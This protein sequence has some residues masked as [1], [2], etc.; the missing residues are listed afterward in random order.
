MFSG[1]IEATGRTL[2]CE[3]VDQSLRLKLEKPSGFNDLSTGDS[4]ACNGVCLT[5]ESQTDGDMGFTLGKETLDVTGWTAESLRNQQWNLERSLRVGDRVHGHMVSG[6]VDGL[7][8][9]AYKKMAGE[10]LLLGFAL[11]DQKSPFVWNK[12]SIALNGV[13]LTVNRFEEGLVEVCL[14]PETLRKTNLGDLS[15]GSSVTYEFDY[16][17]KGLMEAQKK[18]WSHAFPS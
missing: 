3:Y 10:S 8:P 5:L 16:Y 6:H 12:S 9:V 11:A 14:V 17:M 4:I 1:I 15:E 2:E 13:S 18:G 7:V